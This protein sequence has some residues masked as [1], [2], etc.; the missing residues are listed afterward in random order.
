LAELVAQRGLA[1]TGLADEQDQ[2]AVTFCSRSERRLQSAKFSLAADETLSLGDLVLG[3]LRLNGLIGSRR[4]R[5]HGLCRA[6]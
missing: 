3:Q 2:R 4:V 1:D 6:S 5:S